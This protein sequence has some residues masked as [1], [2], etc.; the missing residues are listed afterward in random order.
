MGKLDAMDHLKFEHSRGANM[1]ILAEPVQALNIHI[2]IARVQDVIG[3]WQ[4]VPVIFQTIV[5]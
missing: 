1:M 5:A 4:L 2:M 3:K